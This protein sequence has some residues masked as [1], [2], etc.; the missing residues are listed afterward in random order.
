MAYTDPTVSDFKNYFSRDFPYGVTNDTVK[1]SD[2]VRAMSDATAGTN[3][4]L[5]ISQGFYTIGFLMLSAHNLVMNL[6][7]S[8][9]GIA[10]QY[11]WMQTSKG[12][13]TV[14]ESYVIPQRILDNPELAMLSKTY[15]GAKYLGQILPQLSAAMFSVCGRT[16]P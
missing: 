16:N 12:V 6:R 11:P 3:Q 10:G 1:D 2:I 13:A 4:D 8:A 7:A 14:N 15:Y 5:F 9:Q